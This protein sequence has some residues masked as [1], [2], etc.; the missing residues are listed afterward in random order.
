MKLMT[1]PA[2]MTVVMATTVNNNI[3]VCV[4][5]GHYVPFTG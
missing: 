2:M 1:K 5:A 3:I 4:L